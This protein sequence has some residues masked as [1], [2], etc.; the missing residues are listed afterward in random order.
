MR[1]LA[2]AGTAALLMLSAAA[3]AAAC[4]GPSMHS[5][6]AASAD[7]SAATKKPIRK[8]V[9]RTKEKVEYMRAAPMK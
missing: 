7:L 1:V 4:S 2:I 6:Q 5:V 8:T 9:K 3:P